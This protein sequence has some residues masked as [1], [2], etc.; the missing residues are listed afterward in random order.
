M[1]MMKSAPCLGIVFSSLIAGL[2]VATPACSSNDNSSNGGGA[3]PP[4]LGYITVQS[5][6]GA[7]PSEPSSYN[8]S[9]Y[10][11]G[12]A[13]PT[14]ECTVRTEGDCTILQCGSAGAD[15]GTF[16]YLSAGTLTVSGGLLPAPGVT[17][18]PDADN[19]Y[20][21]AGNINPWHAGQQLTVKGGGG[22]IPIFEVSVSAPTTVTL[23]SPAMPDLGAKITISRTTPLEVHWS[24]EQTEKQIGITSQVLT[25]TGDT[26]AFVGCHFAASETSRTIPASILGVLPK[27]EVF[28]VATT[29]NQATIP[30]GDKAVGLQAE[31]VA[32]SASGGAARGSA[33]ME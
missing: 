29:R 27:G 4:E 22:Q 21:A 30:V 1:R 3:Q 13:D 16:K 6:P 28:I 9:A 8:I 10:F 31:A 7:T 19:N 23:T 2:A 26:T 5:L 33:T 14:P 25:P 17:L 18:E 32:R 15:G 20:L 24:G 11:T 12:G